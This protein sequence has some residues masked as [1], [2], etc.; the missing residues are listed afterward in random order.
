M[1]NRR[2]EATIKVLDDV[3]N[4]MERYERTRDTLNN[5]TFYQMA[6]LEARRLADTYRADAPGRAFWLGVAK[7]LQH[8]AKGY[9][10]AADA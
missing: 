5:G 9:T 7:R 1:A 8:R 2:V 4:M 10:K 6:E 3:A